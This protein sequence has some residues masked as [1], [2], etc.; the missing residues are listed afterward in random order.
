MMKELVNAEQ[1]ILLQFV[2]VLQQNIFKL[3]NINIYKH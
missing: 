2:N 3:I 1:L